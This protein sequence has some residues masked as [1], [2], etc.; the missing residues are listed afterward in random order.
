MKNT[1]HILVPHDFSPCSKQALAKGIEL[2]AQTGAELH[3]LHV[4]VVYSE[5]T[6]PEEAH[7]TKAQIL[8]DHLKQEIAECAA[9]LDLY[10]SDL[11][12]IRYIV[13]RN[14]SASAAIAEYCA[15]Y[16]ID[17]V[18]LGTH[19]R[20]GLSRTLLG[21]VAEEVVRLAPSTVLTVREQEAIVPISDHLNRILVPVDFSDHSRAALQYA[22]E[23]AA[24]FG[25]GLDVVHVIQEYMHPAFSTA[26]I[27]SIYDV[28]PDIESKATE[29]LSA[30]YQAT[31][32]PDVQADFTALY[33]NPAKE[34]I[35]RLTS[36]KAD[37]L[38][39]T[40]H[41]LTGIKR[42]LLGSVAEKLVR[43]APCPVITI[44][45]TEPSLRSLSPLASSY[46]A[47]AA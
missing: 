11:N 25:A 29:A 22:K 43:E 15:D 1:Q 39:L 8:H 4:E 27:V 44:K 23:L 32:G 7:K 47:S 40:T 16:H 26:G 46:K 5:S 3:I 36:N 12:A 28:K 33:G 20:K 45:S 14:Y 2:A 18:V 34:I 35:E 17:L 19:G 13:L 10:V 38:V 37:M 42:T 31:E 9:Q 6:L 30:F 24:S 21:S 41:G